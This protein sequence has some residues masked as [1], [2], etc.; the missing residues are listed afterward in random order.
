[1]LANIS[2]TKCRGEMKMD[3][4]RVTNRMSERKYER[5]SKIEGRSTEE[6]WS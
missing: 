6:G 5:K 2:V 1:M 3:W 4:V